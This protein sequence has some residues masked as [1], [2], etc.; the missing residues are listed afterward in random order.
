[1]T[2]QPAAGEHKDVSASRSRPRRELRGCAAAALYVGW[3]KKLDVVMRQL[4]RAGGKGFVD[5]AGKKRSIVTSQTG[6]THEAKLLVMV[7][8]RGRHTLAHA[9]RTPR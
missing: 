9:I 8:A 4:H 7:R 2:R 5:R 3:R 1:L 6:E